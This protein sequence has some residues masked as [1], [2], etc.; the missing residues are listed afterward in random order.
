M[1]EAD[2]FVRQAQSD[3]AAFELLVARDRS[4]I[5]SCHALHYLQMATEKLSKA[6]FLSLG[7]PYQQRSHVA[8]SLVLAHLNRADMAIKLGWPEFKGYQ[9]FLRRCRRLCRAIEELNPAVG[10]QATGGSTQQ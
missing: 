3:F 6:V 8:F 1:T 5:P 4:E 10:S 2:A 9:R 7:V